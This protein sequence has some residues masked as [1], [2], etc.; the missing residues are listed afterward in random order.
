M[1]PPCSSGPDLYYSMGVTLYSAG[2]SSGLCRRQPVPWVAHSGLRCSLP[3]GC[4]SVPGFHTHVVTLPLLPTNFCSWSQGLVH[5]LACGLQC[6]QYLALPSAFRPNS[7]ACHG[8]WHRP[9]W[10]PSAP[11]FLHG[12]P[13][14]TRP[15]DACVEIM[16]L[17][18]SSGSPMQSQSP[19]S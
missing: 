7:P 8:G 9:H 5:H 17:K 19:A 18:P 4:I 16:L 6:V 14:G 3:P 11:A 12:Q 1:K 15:Q 2:Q 13:G 10:V